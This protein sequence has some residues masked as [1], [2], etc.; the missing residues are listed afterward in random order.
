MKYRLFTS[1]S[2]TEG[3][4]DK[5]CDSISD[6]VLDAVLTVDSDAHCA[7]ETCATTDMVLVMGEIRSNARVDID[8]IVRD[9]VKNIGYDRDC[10]GFDSHTL[11]VIN[12]RHAQSVDIAKGVDTSEEAQ[13]EADDNAYDRQGA[14][15]QGRSS[16][17][18]GSPSGM[19]SHSGRNGFAPN[20]AAAHSIAA[21][22]TACLFICGPRFP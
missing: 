22:R 6:A 9:P 13:E 7:C 10:F 17:T 8:Q 12:R 15:D 2:V 3:H 1:E 4:P 5:V 19:Y 14:G 16:K 18:C 21:M 20:D 11:T